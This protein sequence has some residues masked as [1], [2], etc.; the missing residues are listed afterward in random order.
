MV[1]VNSTVASERAWE[2][3]LR[4]REEKM[5]LTPIKLVVR[6]AHERGDAQ[7]QGLLCQV[8]WREEGSAGSYAES[9][10]AGSK[11]FLADSGGQE[12]GEEEGGEEEEGIGC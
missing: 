9:G 8:G 1:P 5:A 2:A 10:R 12:I 7:R 11:K 3:L 4:R 6:D